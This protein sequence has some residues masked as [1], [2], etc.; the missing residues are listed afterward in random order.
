MTAQQ[1]VNISATYPASIASYILRNLLTGHYYIGATSN[2]AK[3]LRDHR[4]YL[5]TS[6]HQ[7]PRFN[8]VFSGWDNT[9]VEYT[10]HET[11]DIAKGIEQA[12]I[13]QH[14]PE[15]LCCNVCTDVLNFWGG[16]YGMPDDVRKRIG[17]AHRGT[18]HSEEFREKCRQRMLGSVMPE[19]QKEKI[20]K[21]LQGKVVSNETRR[22]LSNS[23]EGKLK[24]RTRSPE[25][26]AKGIATRAEKGINKHTPES[27]AK[28]AQAGMKPVLVDGVEYP[29]MGS[30]ASKFGITISAV[31]YRIQSTSDKFSGW[32]FKI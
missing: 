15:S 8:S 10:L 25:S 30:L 31:K 29:S 27:R 4:H 7:N 22:R 3:R 26:V 21:K 28:I 2:L 5:E 14:Y 17:D 19:E 20:S 13:N 16:Q 18:K 32:Q 6:T 12:L 9:A 1:R 24:G 11:I 23:L